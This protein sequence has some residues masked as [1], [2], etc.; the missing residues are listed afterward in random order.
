MAIVKEGYKVFI[1]FEAKLDTGEIVLKT[2]DDKPLEITVGDGAIPKSIEKTLID[3]KEGETKTI[4]LEP[5]ESFGP[6][7]NELVI[8]LPKQGFSS[9][10]DLMIG[11][12]VNLTSPENKTY[13]GT[14]IEIKDES[15]TVDFNHP[16]AGKSLIFTVTVVSVE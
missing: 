8:D 9:D 4:T 15:V 5:A 7:V 12:R 11:S 6:R 2:E 16:L 1:L 14:V 3:M 13:T 10:F